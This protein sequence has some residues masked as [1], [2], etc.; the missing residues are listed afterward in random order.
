MVTIFDQD[1]TLPPVEVAES[2]VEGIEIKPDPDTLFKDIDVTIEIK[3]NQVT[4][5]QRCQN[6]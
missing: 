2:I 3:V 1:M 4:S 5:S 6:T